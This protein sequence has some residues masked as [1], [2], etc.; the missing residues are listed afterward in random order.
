MHSFIWFDGSLFLF[1]S[2]FL[3]LFDFTLKCSCAYLHN[4]LLSL[5]LSHI[6]LVVMI[7][8]RASISIKVLA[9]VFQSS[10]FISCHL[11]LVKNCSN[12]PLLF[13][14]SLAEML[15]LLLLEVDATLTY[16]NATV[17]HARQVYTRVFLSPSIQDWK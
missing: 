3:P 2:F 8:L 11:V 10:F 17:L 5:S 4:R 6:V 14:F 15:L 13:R 1:L 9:P 12:I 7:H 16:I